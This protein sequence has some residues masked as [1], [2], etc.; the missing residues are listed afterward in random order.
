MGHAR[1]RSGG[2]KLYSDGHG[3][4][5]LLSHN[6]KRILWA[7]QMHILVSFIT[8][9]LLLPSASEIYQQGRPC[10]HQQFPAI[11]NIFPITEGQRCSANRGKLRKDKSQLW[12]GH[13]KGVRNVPTGAESGR[14]YCLKKPLGTPVV[15]V[16]CLL[17]T[18]LCAV[19]HLGWGPLQLSNKQHR[20][21]AKRGLQ[22]AQLAVRIIPSRADCGKGS[23]MAVVVV[24]HSGHVLGEAHMTGLD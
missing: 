6:P 5:F 2:P 14:G 18:P 8:I 16:M 7:D 21:M 12:C 23:Q 20:L 3:G 1:S 10:S 15:L 17:A 4:L 9:I 19:M 22:F 24:R 13:H 11:T